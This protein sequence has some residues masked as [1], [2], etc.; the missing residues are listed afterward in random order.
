VAQWVRHL[1]VMSTSTGVPQIVCGRC[2]IVLPTLATLNTPVLTKEDRIFLGDD[3][4]A[5]D[6]GT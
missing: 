4:R 1:A 3:P 6:C 2:G 5:R